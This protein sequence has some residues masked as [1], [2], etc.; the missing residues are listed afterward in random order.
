MHYRLAKAA[1]DLHRE[2]IDCLGQVPR[3]LSAL[4]RD[5]QRL[6]G[7]HLLWGLTNFFDPIHPLRRMYGNGTMETNQ[8]KTFG[9]EAKRPAA[10][11]A[12]APTPMP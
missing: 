6:E 5:R 9:G 3:G 2:V 8:L 12:V 1:G 4:T 10:S 7:R 11:L